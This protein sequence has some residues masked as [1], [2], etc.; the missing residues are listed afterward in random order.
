MTSTSE[1]TAITHI[2]GGERIESGPAQH[3]VSPSDSTD[4]VASWGAASEDLARQA[5]EAAVAAAPGWAATTGAQRGEILT[6]AG[7]ELD[8]RANELGR[9][10]AREEGKTLP[11][12]IAEVRRAAQIFL[13]QGG[14]AVRNRGQL[15]DSVR[16]DVEI[17]IT[18]EPLGVVSVIAPWNFP[19]AIP[20]WKIAPALAYGNTVI[21][22]PSEAVP[23]SAWHLVDVLHRAGLPN[24]VL[25]LVLGRGKDIGDTL[26][27]SVGIDAV[28]FTGSESTGRRVLDRTS[29]AGIRAQL[30]MGGKNPLVVL[31]D[32]DI[33]VAVTQALTG[34]FG[35]TGQRCTASSRLIVTR[36]IHDRFVDRLGAAMAAWRVGHALGDGID[37]GPV[38]D[39]GQLDKDRRYVAAAAAA[40]REV[41]GGQ[42]EEAETDGFFMRPALVL[43][44][45]PTDAINREEVFGPVASVIKVD[46]YQH[47]LAV[48]NDTPYGLTAGIITTSLAAAH[49]FRKR[50]QAGMVMVNLATAGVDFHVPFGGRGASSFGPREQGEHAR[51][52]FTQVKTAY[53]AAG[54]AS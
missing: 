30:E 4:I 29:A 15:I 32:A 40:G 5:I 16:A 45:E 34:A 54:A 3:D 21:L 26:T 51:E 37:M 49:D 28:T 7:L 24:G 48:A 19:I 46:D 14:Q 22:K 18:R 25:N 39:Q 8:R 47:A 23:A 2:I 11:E 44:T 12:A 50:A 10:L 52:F 20:A 42:L 43:G 31:D 35:S 36:G 17:S 6:N 41:V 33:D 38:V 27:G 53:V 9:V 1:T 13:F